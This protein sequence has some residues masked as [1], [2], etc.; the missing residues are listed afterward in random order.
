VRDQL[1]S[2]KTG[3]GCPTASR[4]R[5]RAALVGN[6][7]PAGIGGR[8]GVGEHEQRSGKLARG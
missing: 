8:L 2:N 4:R 3:E 1:E 5:R 7:A 6:G